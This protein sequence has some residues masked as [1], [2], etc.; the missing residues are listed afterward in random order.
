MSQGNTISSN[1]SLLKRFYTHDKVEDAS[2]DK[3][4]LLALLPKMENVGGVDYNVPVIYSQ[5]QGRSKLF[6]TAQAVG[7]VSGTQSVQFRLPM[8]ED[9]QDST[10]STGLVLASEG[11]KEGAFLENMAQ[12][13]DGA[14]SNMS[15]QLEQKLFGDGSGSRG[16]VSTATT[17]ASSTLILTNP[18]DVLKFENGMNLQFAAT[19]GGSILAQ[20]SN[21][22]DLVVATVNYI[23]GSFTVQGA[24]GVA[25]NLNDSVYG[26]PTIATG[27]FIFQS[28]DQST[29]VSLD[30]G[31]SGNVLSG[32][33]A[34][35]PYGGP[36]SNDSFSLSGVN[37][38]INNVRLAGLYMDGTGLSTEEA[39]IKGAA[40]VTKHG[41]DIDT[42]IMNW[43]KFA[44]LSVSLSSKIQII[45]MKVSPSVGFQTMKIVGP[46][47]PIRVIGARNCPST[48]IF[49]LKMST[50]ELV[51][52][53]KS[54]F[55]WDLDGRDFLRQGTDS[56]MELRVASYANLFCHKPSANINIKV[57]AS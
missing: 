41:D 3:C 31:S 9:W 14:I 57:Q 21:G 56:G 32:L 6:P 38:S 47:G 37:R 15:I 17:V 26:V 44:A 35:L 42:Y 30:G 34:W 46:N 24:N 20:G 39:L 11:G 2:F 40:L 1:I 25:C 45:D 12:V 8:T 4:P 10:I 7:A 19:V 49:G 28:G 23:A 18:E 36:A 5:G 53:R 51:S 43:P 27:N 50:W 52:M 33:Q 22:T 13:V 54:V 55:I 48:T 29:S 16:T